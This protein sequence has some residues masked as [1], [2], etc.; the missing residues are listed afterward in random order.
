MNVYNKEDKKKSKEIKQKN[1]HYY[2]N[3]NKK[4][5]GG[6]NMEIIKQHKIQ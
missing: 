5:P 6:D 3:K 2:Y 1:K 4:V